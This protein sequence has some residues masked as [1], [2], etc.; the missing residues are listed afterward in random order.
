[1]GDKEIYHLYIRVRLWDSTPI[2]VFSNYLYNTTYRT[3]CQEQSIY[4]A[5]Y[6]VFFL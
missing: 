1:M 5:Q 2:H 4:R 3:T 6:I